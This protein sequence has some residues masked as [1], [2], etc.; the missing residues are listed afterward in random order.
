MRYAD[1][2]Q[3]SSAK[4]NFLKGLIRLAKADKIIEPEE[5][6]YFRA[7][8]AQLDLNE[9]ELNEVDQYWTQD[10]LPVAFKT[11]PEKI[12]FVREALQLCAIDNRYADEEK[13]EIRKVCAELGVSNETLEKLEAWV[14]EG[15]NW[16]QRGDEFLNV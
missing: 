10:S 11:M 9:E 2:F 12:L 3:S 16:K 6:M 4:I 5:Q 13:Q 15:M 1:I 8:G 7:A 14:E